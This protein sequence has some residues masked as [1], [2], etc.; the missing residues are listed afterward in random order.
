MA[1]SA[2]MKARAVVATYSVMVIGL[3][4]V[5]GLAREPSAARM[6]LSSFWAGAAHIVQLG[7][8]GFEERNFQPESDA[9]CAAV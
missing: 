4:P 7:P 3:A 8:I 5:L 2:A 9:E 6:L 1:I